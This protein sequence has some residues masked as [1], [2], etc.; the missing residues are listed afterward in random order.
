MINNKRVAVVL[1]AYRA[2]K[3]LEKTYSEIPLDIVDSILLVDDCS[4]D[5][6]VD[7]AAKLGIKM[8]KHERN[9]GYG[10]N[11]KTCYKTALE[12]NADIIV[13]LHPDYQYTPLLITAM[14][15]MLAYGVYDTVLGSR[16]IGRG[17]IIGGMPKYKYIANRFLT[18]FQ[19][20]LMGEK[21]SEY[22]TGYRG[23]T[24]EVLQTLD[25]SPN[26]NDFLF[27]NEMLAQIFYCG[28]KVGEISCPTRYE[29]D[30]SSIALRPSIEY[31]VGVLLV[32]CKYLL[33][34]KGFASFA[35]F[36]N[37]KIKAT[38]NV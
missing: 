34:T 23:F 6:T 28:F 18:L 30:S 10:G 5:H 11:Q 16:I 27:D 37:L 12:D 22:H 14:A 2:E 1:P 19:N 13:M 24:A 32:S 17:A 29:T 4:P 15:S 31:G 3:T 8:V 7:V 38:T 35:L 26:S 20:L 25:L 21:L 36:K 9:L 33:Q